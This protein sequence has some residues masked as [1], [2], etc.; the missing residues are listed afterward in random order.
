MTSSNAGRGLSCVWSSGFLESE[1]T[2]PGLRTLTGG[3]QGLYVI[4]SDYDWNG[5]P[6]QYAIGATTSLTSPSNTTCPP[7]G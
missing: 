3:P 1:T 7:A 5:Q 4:T 6:L 2:A